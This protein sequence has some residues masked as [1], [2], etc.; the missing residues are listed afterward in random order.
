MIVIDA[1][2]LEDGGLDVMDVHASFSMNVSFL[3]A[4]SSH[5]ERE[6]FSVMIASIGIGFRISLAVNG[7][8]EFAAPNNQGVVEQASTLQ[9]HDQSRAGLIRVPRGNRQALVQ[10]AVVIPA[11]MVQLHEAHAAFTQATGH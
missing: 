5:P 3:N 11:S 1:K 8:A 10:T 2:L 9:V 7:A 4:C 6:R